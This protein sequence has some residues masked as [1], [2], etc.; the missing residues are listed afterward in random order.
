MSDTNQLNTRRRRQVAVPQA[1]IMRAG[2][3]AQA[4]GPT[5]RVY[6]DGN[7]IHLFQGEAPMTPA[8]STPVAPDK[9]WRL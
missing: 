3:V 7:V 4:L 8:A 9:R 6:I 1:Q 2:R 5:W